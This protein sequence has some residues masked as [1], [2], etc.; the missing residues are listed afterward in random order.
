MGVS[1]IA[2]PQGLAQVLNSAGDKSNVDFDYLLQTAIR[3][4]S[5]KPDAKAPSSSAVGLFQFLESTWMQVMKEQGPR[6]GYQKYADAIT[7]DSDGDYIIK[8]KAMRTEILALRE[9]PQVAADMAA[10]FTQSNGDYLQAKFGRMPSPGELYIAHFLGP[11]GAEK[12][13]SAGLS[14]PDQIAAKIFP[15]Q[16]KAN[17]QIFYANGEART[18]KELYRSLVAKHLGTPATVTVDDPKFAAQQMAATPDARWATE[19]VPSRF[20]KDDMSFTSFFATEPPRAVPQPLIATDALQSLIGE[21]PTDPLVS[22]Y[23]SVPA[24]SEPQPLDLELGFVP[25]PAPAPLI[26]T[27]APIMLLAGGV[28]PIAAPAV[29][30]PPK[31]R[32]LMSREPGNSAFLTQLYVQE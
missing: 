30:E 5:L 21:Q 22:A 17:P 8:N 24:G 11:Q 10:A 15:K 6:L 23:A 4:S 3:E 28:V 32:V 12:L 9:D 29:D 7:T 1:P 18:I 25:L 19:A 31:A 20:S 14:N 16:A 26:P 27:E 2:V 13:F